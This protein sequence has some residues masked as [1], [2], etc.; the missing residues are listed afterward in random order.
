MLECAEF[1]ALGVVIGMVTSHTEEHTAYT[2]FLIT[3]MGFFCG[4]FFPLSALPGWAA[5]LLSWLPL[6]PAVAALRLGHDG[7]ALLGLCVYA[8]FVHRPRHTGGGDLPRVRKR[9]MKLAAIVWASYASMLKEAF[10]AEGFETAVF[11]SKRLAQNPSEMEAAIVGMA[12]ADLILL[13][14]TNEG[15]W[16]EIEAALP[17]GVPVVVVGMD[18]TLWESATTPIAIC[19]RAHAYLHQNGATN[20]SRLARFLKAEV[21]NLGGEVEEPAPEPWEGLYHPALG[22]VFS[23]VDGY[24]AA[25]SKYLGESPRLLSA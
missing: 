16:Q 3:P 6:G 5:T 13:Y 1:A 23:N 7:A 15:Y 14:R 17:A 20:L 4:V 25:Y 12:D 22:Q 10:A 8:L 11:A 18:P 24:L 21:L 19:A 9:T 2:N